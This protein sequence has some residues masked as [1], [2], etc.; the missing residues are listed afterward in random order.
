MSAV[1]PRDPLR[2]GLIGTLA[3]V[4]V[5]LGLF[6]L[7]SLPFIG[8]GRVGYRADFADAGGLRSGDPVE[9][10]GVRVGAVSGIAIEADHVVIS[11]RIRTHVHL[12][13]TTA[14]GV[15]VG[16]LLGAKY[17]ELEPHGAGSLAHGATIPLNRTTA[18]YDIV[19]AFSQLTETAGEIDKKHVAEALNTIADTFA[20]SPSHV[21]G[22]LHGLADFSAAI[23]DRDSEVKDLLRHARVTTEVL[24]KRRGDIG[25]LITAS[26]K[27]LG[28]LSTRRAAIHRLLTTTTA[29][30][31]ELQG[32]VTDNQAALNPALNNLH[33][34]IDMLAHRQAEISATVKNMDVFTRAF[35]NTVG[36]GAWF[37]AIIP[38]VGTRVT[39]GGA[40]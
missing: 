22:V 33:G 15:K 7:D 16:S 27:I 1:R 24:A 14:A 11:F 17:L 25:H 4:V 5:L 18:A 29:L 20:G 6:R 28:E 32:V 2:L 19:E 37:D 3:V 26:N 23:A 21:R 35:T 34:V 8:A 39:F 13:A 40:P 9:I 38:N 12:G 10:S 36:S 31:A 30:A